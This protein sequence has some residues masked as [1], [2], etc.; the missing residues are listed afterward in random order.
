MSQTFETKAPR[1]VPVIKV[2]DL[3]VTFQGRSGALSGL[4]GKRAAGARAV[5]G[6]SLEL[7]RGEI[8]ALAGESGCGKTTLAR[9]I[10]GL[11]TPTSGDLLFEGKPVKDLRAYRR[12]VQM[13]FQDPTGALN[14]R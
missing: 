12:R 3:G 13:V 10:M 4:F 6:V 11:E 9:T 2:T 8:L 7:M 14:P 5:D 1:G